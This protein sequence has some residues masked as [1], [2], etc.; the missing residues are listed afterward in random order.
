MK[1]K[2]RRRKFII[3][4]K[5]LKKMSQRGIE[6]LSD[7]CEGSI[8]TIILLRLIYN[9][10]NSLLILNNSNLFEIKHQNCSTDFSFLSQYTAIFF[11]TIFFQ[12]IVLIKKCKTYS[13]KHLN[14]FVIHFIDHQSKISSLI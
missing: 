4:F 2:T 8:L 14:R 5:F 6:P 3:F 9:W 10:N 1:K 12:F 13:Q 11:Q 7:P